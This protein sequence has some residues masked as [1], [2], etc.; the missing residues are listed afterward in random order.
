MITFAKAQATS[1]TASVV[2]YLITILCVEVL[3]MFYFFGS[4]TG[5]IAGG[6]VNFSLARR[7]VFRSTGE[8]RRLQ[9]LYFVI[10]WLGYLF[11]IT[12]GVYLLT[13]FL[14]WNYLVS[15]VIVSLVLAFCYNYPIQKSFVFAKNKTP[16]Y[17][18]KASPR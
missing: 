9:I 13:H 18:S 7:W 6:A 12:N 17:G 16:E 4:A 3:G 15:K 14:E 5:T 1:F 11:L 8:D 2:D 10:V